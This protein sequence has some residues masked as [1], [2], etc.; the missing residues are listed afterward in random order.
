[1]NDRFFRTNAFLG[2]ENAEKLKESVVA[3]FGIG[4]VGSYTVEALARSGVGCLFLY[5]NDTVEESNINRQ[6]IALSSTVG[7]FK[8]EAAKK[9]CMDINPDIKVFTFNEFI[10]KN[11][12]LPFD[13]FDFIVDAVD[14]VEAKVF[15]AKSAQDKDIPIISVMGTGNKV[16]PENLKIGDIYKTSECPLC[17]KMRY[18]LKK[19]DVKK[20]MCVWSD[21]RCKNISGGVRADGHA[22]PSSMIFVPATAG[23]LAAKYVVTKISEG[24]NLK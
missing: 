23:L 13:E 9:R 24:D 14:N 5:D 1:M 22:A 18:E 2:K 8:T 20:L 12:A 6:I 21:E 4:G 16:N 17:R 11:S 19:A 10:S 7:Q 3:V 15:L